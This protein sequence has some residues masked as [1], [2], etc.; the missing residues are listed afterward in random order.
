MTL[1]DSLNET[2][3]FCVDCGIR[4]TS[5]QNAEGSVGRYLKLDL[6]PEACSKLQHELELAPMMPMKTENCDWTGTWKEW[7]AAYQ[8]WTK[9]LQELQGNLKVEG[10]YGEDIEEIRAAVLDCVVTEAREVHGNYSIF[11]GS[12]GADPGPE[13]YCWLENG[14]LRA[15]ENIDETDME[16]IR[17][18]YIYSNTTV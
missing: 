9:F 1:T 6:H 3:V 7:V 11:V 12:K 8:I 15:E 10:L 17:D 18:Q 5:H 16:T 13:I 4:N 14:E 2:P